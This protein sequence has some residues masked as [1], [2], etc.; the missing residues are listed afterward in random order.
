MQEANQAVMPGPIGQGGEVGFEIDHSGFE[1]AKKLVE[2]SVGLVLQPDDRRSQFLALP[3]C[4]EACVD[5]HPQAVLKQHDGVGDCQLMAGQE[6]MA[7]SAEGGD[8]G[9][10]EG[11]P[12]AGKMVIR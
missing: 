10:G 2:E 5:V 3:A 9:V 7:Q 8:V 4:R 6:L 11:R 1:A 12:D